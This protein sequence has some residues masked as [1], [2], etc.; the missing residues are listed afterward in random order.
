MYI[1]YQYLLLI[2]FLHVF[3]IIVYKGCIKRFLDHT[4]DQSLQ[5]IIKRN[6]TFTVC[7]HGHAPDVSIGSPRSSQQ[8]LLYSNQECCVI[9]Q[10]NS[11]HYV[12]G[13]WMPIQKDVFSL[14]CMIGSP[15]KT[16]LQVL[17]EYSA[18]MCIV[19]CT[20]YNIIKI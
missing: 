14:C 15:T 10:N 1:H 11:L 16:V 8:G 5:P 13:K 12:G 6:G 17:Q 4:G 9:N 7:E 20:I 19:N 2:Q 3:N 18:Y